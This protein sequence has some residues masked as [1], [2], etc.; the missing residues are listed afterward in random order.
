MEIDGKS[1]VITVQPVLDTS[2]YTSGDRMGAVTK[3]ANV[4]NG[5]NAHLR[6]LMILDQAKQSVAFDI[7][8]FKASPTVASA[9]NAAI[10]VSDAEML[11]KCVGKLSVAAAD[12]MALAANSVAM[13]GNLFLTFKNPGSEVRDLWILLIARGAPT[14]AA[15]SLA[16]RFGFIQD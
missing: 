7:L 1:T 15:D 6:S 3:L 5:G 12:F 9:D 14:F 11:D 8:F 16:L 13:Y 2:A 4:F 10:D